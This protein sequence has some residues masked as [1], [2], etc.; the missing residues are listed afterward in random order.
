MFLRFNEL[1]V[2]DTDAIVIADLQA[3]LGDIIDEAGLIGM[4]G[5]PVVAQVK[6]YTPTVPVGGAEVVFYTDIGNEKQPVDSIR[7]QGQPLR[8]GKG[9][10]LMSCVHDLCSHRQCR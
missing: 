8:S 3:S 5:L 2:E 9:V 7:T 10:N 4:A 6:A 1:S